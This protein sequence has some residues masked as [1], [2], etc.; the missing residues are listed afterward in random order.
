MT[1]SRP[2]PQKPERHPAVD[3]AGPFVLDT[4]DLGRRAGSMLKMSR[5]VDAPADMGVAVATIAEGSAIDLE[6]RL[7]SVIEGV[8]VSGTAEVMVAAECSR[9]LDPLEWDQEVWFSE[10]F[11]Y[12]D[13]EGAG[14]EEEDEQPVLEDDFIDLEPTVRDAVVSTLPFAPVCRDDCPGLCT[15]CGARLADDPEHAH[16]EVDPRWAALAGLTMNDEKES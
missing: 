7:E 10:L 11:R 14:R 13:L 9:C 4:R 15:T 6:V 2:R 5:V 1:G 8:L 16:D 3:P 12:P